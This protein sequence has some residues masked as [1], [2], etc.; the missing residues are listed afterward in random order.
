MIP[1]VD[2]IRFVNL[3]VDEL[4]ANGFMSPERLFE[5]PY[6]DHAP[7][8]PDF[9]FPDDDVDVIVEILHDIRHHAVPT[10]VA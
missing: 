10:E 5:S 8:G 4:T 1:P 7:T 3:I 9:F 2:Q 6:T